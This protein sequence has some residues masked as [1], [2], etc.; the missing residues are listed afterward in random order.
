VGF[1]AGF[2]VAVVGGRVVVRAGVAEVVGGALVEPPVVAED[3]D[4]PPS[5]PAHPAKAR[6]APRRHAAYRVERMGHPLCRG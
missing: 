5:W 1:G 6:V 3:A 4:W 2:D